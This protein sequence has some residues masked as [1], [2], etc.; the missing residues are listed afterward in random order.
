MVFPPTSLYRIISHTIP[1]AI[2]AHTLNQ[3]LECLSYSLL[4]RALAGLSFM[5][6]LRLWLVKPHAVGSAQ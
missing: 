4:F 5:A 1:T 3:I 2:A 6:G